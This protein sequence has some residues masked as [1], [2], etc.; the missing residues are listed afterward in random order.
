MSILNDIVQ[1]IKNF[2]NDRNITNS[3]HNNTITEDKDTNIKNDTID[4]ETEQPT[5]KTVNKNRLQKFII[6]GIVFIICVIFGATYGKDD[7]PKTKEVEVATSS[8]NSLNKEIIGDDYDNIQTKKK[9]G[10]YEYNKTHKLQKENNINDNNELNNEQERD[11]Y[12]ENNRSYERN[13]NSYNRP[14]P[15]LNNNGAYNP[16]PY[17]NVVSPVPR[18][19]IVQQPVQQ[20]QKSDNNNKKDDTKN[21]FESA[22]AFISDTNTKNTNDNQDNTNNTTQN[23]QL[24]SYTAPAPNTLQAGT[25]IPLILL[26]G[27][28]SQTGG[29]IMAQVQTNVYDSLDGVNILIPM[30]SKLVGKYAN[31]AKQ[32]Q[33]RVNIN[34]EHLIMPDGSMYNVDGVFQT[35]DQNGYPGIPGDVNNHN[36]EKIS[37]GMFSSALAALGSIATGNNSYGNDYGWHDS[38]QLAMQGASANLLNTASSIFKQK[39]DIEPEITVEA[40]TTFYV[41]LTQSIS[42]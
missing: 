31:G 24:M 15:I 28:N 20:T 8:D 22:I 36:S 26:N 11:S 12:S 16:N 21:I 17:M 7:S 41:Y 38:G 10:D 33:D 3:I 19:Q 23:S 42:F 14:V 25:Y 18:T 37:A 9:L 6:L 39:L 30:G 1:S 32:G 27:I 4:N 40:G 13:N 2:K 29:Q 34:W 5:T 35:S